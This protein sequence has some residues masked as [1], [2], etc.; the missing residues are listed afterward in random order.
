M[1]S[2][3]REAEG[4]SLYQELVQRWMLFWHGAFYVS[5]IVATGLAVTFGA[6]DLSAKPGSLRALAGA[7]NLVYRMS[8]QIE[9]YW[10]ARVLLTWGY[11]L[12]GWIIWTGLITQ[13]P[14]YL[15]LL[16]ASLSAALCLPAFPLVYC[17]CLHPV[18]DY[19]LEPGDGTGGL[20]CGCDHPLELA[21]ECRLRLVH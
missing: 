4:G 10:R 6:F 3:S 19:A 1:T 18:R 11:L 15:F 5:L 20:G 14:I 16:F 9:E 13:S 2:F 21:C 7:G 12:I 17:R 8:P